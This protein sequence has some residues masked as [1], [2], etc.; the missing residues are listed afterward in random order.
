M[1][2]LRVPLTKNKLPTRSR[3]PDALADEEEPG[4]DFEVLG[5]HHRSLVQI[6]RSVFS[7]PSARRFHFEPFKA[8]LRWK[9]G[10]VERVYDE[11]YNSDSFL[12]EHEKLRQAPR[13]PGC[14]HPITIAAIQLWSDSMQVTQFAHTKLWPI[15]LSFGNQSKYTRSQPRARACHHVAHIPSVSYS[16]SHLISST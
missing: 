12:R 6:I 7:S 5:L 15:Y 3:R 14:P 2:K 4:V 10:K 1:L 16:H 11:L 9:N 8:F 13:E